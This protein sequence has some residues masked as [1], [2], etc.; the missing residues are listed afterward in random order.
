M[1]NTGSAAEFIGH[2]RHSFFVR[3]SSG[4][5]FC[6]DPRNP[7]QADPIPQCLVGLYQRMLGAVLVLS[8]CKN[9]AATRFALLSLIL[10]VAVHG[11]FHSRYLQ[12]PRDFPGGFR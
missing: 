8:P 9:A 12:K 2:S 6:R 11:S 5:F 4:I 7:H 3:R 10:V 1:T